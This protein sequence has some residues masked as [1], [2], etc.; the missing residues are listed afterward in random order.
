M[1]N[2][3]PA[4]FYFSILSLLFVPLLSNQIRIRLCYF[5]FPPSKNKSLCVSEWPLWL[6]TAMG[7]FS[8]VHYFPLSISFR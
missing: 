1:L 4:S 3:S 8:T 7:P 2:H 5:L 6:V